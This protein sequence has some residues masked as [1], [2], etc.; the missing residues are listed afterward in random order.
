M[1]RGHNT[2]TFHRIMYV[3]DAYIYIWCHSKLEAKVAFFALCTDRWLVVRGTIV[4]RT[5]GEHKNYI[6]LICVYSYP[7][8]FLKVFGVICYEYLVAVNK[9]PAMMKGMHCLSPATRVRHSVADLPI[10]FPLPE[11]LHMS[12]TYTQRAYTMRGR[13]TNRVA[14]RK[15][16]DKV[17][18][19]RKNN[20][21]PF[22]SE[23][24]F[25]RESYEWAMLKIMLHIV[26]WQG[27]W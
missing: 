6:L 8:F 16:D 12:P 5:D 3:Y 27:K 10:P 22:V 14:A 20:R 17:S 19:A 23:V 2:Y 9:R 7:Y 4:H 26:G 13:D 1:Y 24:F 25:F 18:G 15:A 21:F 11:R